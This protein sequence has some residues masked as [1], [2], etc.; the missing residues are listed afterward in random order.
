[1]ILYI[2]Q[3]TAQRSDLLDGE[4]TAVACQNVSEGGVRALNI[5]NDIVE[6]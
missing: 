3:E 2:H 5:C 1:M 4:I 6:C